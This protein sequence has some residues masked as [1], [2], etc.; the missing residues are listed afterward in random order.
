MSFRSITRAG[1]RRR[2]S[3][4]G[5][6]NDDN[7]DDDDD[8]GSGCTDIGGNKRKV[9]YIQPDITKYKQDVTDMNRIAKFLV[10]ALSDGLN[11]CRDST[12]NRSEYFI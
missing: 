6:G 10:L 4:K 11:A 5:G 2:D 7:D 3:I 1:A 8:D 9:L 12:R